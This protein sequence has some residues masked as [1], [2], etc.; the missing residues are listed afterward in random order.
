VKESISQA[1][2][3]PLGVQ[4]AERPRR[5]VA[6]NQIAAFWNSMIGKKVV[7]A[8]TG[9]VLVLFVLM[10]MIGNLKILSGPDN[11]NAYAVFLREVG[12]PELGYGQLLWIVR[13]VLLICVILHVTAVIQPT[14]DN[15]CSDNALGW[16]RVAGIHHFSPLAP[17]RWSRRIQAR[18]IQAS[19]GLP[20][21][22]RRIV[23][24]AHC[25]LLHRGNGC[26]ND[27]PLS[28]NLERLPDARSQHFPEH[29]D[30]ADRVPTDC[31]GGVCRFRLGTRLCAGRVVALKGG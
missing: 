16:C 18:P 25:R 6:V 4:A 9:A 27:A 12:R 14:N 11:I 20:E 28:R 1:G 10:H 15:C 26:A 7:M 13:V 5:E 19:C 3:A 31:S 22:N 29:S 21:C 8:T 2:P 24:L 30:L 17:H 23:V